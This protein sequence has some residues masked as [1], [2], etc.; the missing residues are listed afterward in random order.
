MH[1]F[2]KLPKSNIQLLWNK[3]KNIENVIFF[4]FLRK[5]LVVDNRRFN[6]KTKYGMVF[7]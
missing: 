2:T 7:K 4:F 6:N 3:L 5:H 1:L